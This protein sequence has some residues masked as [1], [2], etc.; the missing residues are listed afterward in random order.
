MEASSIVGVT[1]P[2][3]ANSNPDGRYGVIAAGRESDRDAVGRTAEGKTES[4][5]SAA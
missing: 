1:A 2:L 3:D 4:K 5:S